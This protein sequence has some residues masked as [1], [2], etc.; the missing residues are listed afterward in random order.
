VA[1]AT[2]KLLIIKF[3]LKLA[4]N[5]PIFSNF[6]H[7]TLPLAANSW[8]PIKE[9]KNQSFYNLTNNNNLR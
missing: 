4:L 8:L 6:A 7:R 9:Q 2:S 5:I 1:G 3:Y